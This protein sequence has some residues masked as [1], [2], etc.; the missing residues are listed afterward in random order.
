MIAGFGAALAAKR[1]GGPLFG[2][3][4]GGK[5]AG[6]VL[7]GALLAAPKI[8]IPVALWIVDLVLNAIVQILRNSGM[9]I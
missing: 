6:A 3:S 4:G 8:V 7:V 5:F 2:G 9:G 1:R